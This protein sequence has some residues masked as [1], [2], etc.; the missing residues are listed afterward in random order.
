MLLKHCINQERNIKNKTKVGTTIQR[1]SKLFSKNDEKGNLLNLTIKGNCTSANR[2]PIKCSEDPNQ[3][4]KC[5]D[6]PM[7]KILDGIISRLLK[8]EI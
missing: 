3:L 6:V 5:L 1:C 8:Y 4:V 2:L 7:V